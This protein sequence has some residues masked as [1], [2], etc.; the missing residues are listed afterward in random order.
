MID[1]RYVVRF[2]SQPDISF[3]ELVELLRRTLLSGTG[4]PEGVYAFMP[5]EI[6]RHFSVVR[7]D[8][9]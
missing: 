9:L 6:K 7:E 1:I 2:T 4:S 5:P 8:N 3:T